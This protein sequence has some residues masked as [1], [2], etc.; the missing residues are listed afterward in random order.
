[1]TS[2]STINLDSPLSRFVVLENVTSL[3][4]FSFFGTEGVNL[5]MLKFGISKGPQPSMYYF[6]D[7]NMELYMTFFF[8]ILL[9]KMIVCLR[10]P[11]CT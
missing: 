11:K 6:L 10:F 1:M 2:P 9:N 4:R 8:P 7:L 5:S 3:P